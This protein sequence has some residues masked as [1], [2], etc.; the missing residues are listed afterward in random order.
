[1]SAALLSFFIVLLAGLIFSELF[2]RFHLPW[3]LALILA[4][5]VIGPYAADIITID[6]TL[7]F[8]GQIGLVF[9]MFMGGLEA[10]LSSFRGL[11]REIVITTAFNS[12]IPFA[13]GM[14][15]A[16]TFSYSLNAAI[17]LGVIF[18]SSSVSVVL[19]ALERSGYIRNSV[20]R[21][22]LDV[23]IIEDILSLILLSII[24]QT[25]NSLSPLPLYVLYPLLLLIF[26]GLRWI[27][28]H[29]SKLML[30]LFAD[31]TSRGGSHELQVVFVVLI[32]T[33]IIFQILGLHP[34]IGSFL[35]GLILSD[36]IK[37]NGLKNKLRAMGYGL[38]IPIFFVL[39]GMRTNIFAFSDARY[40][41][42][43]TISV[44]S[45]L[46]IAKFTG[47]WLG[48]KLS[49]LSNYNASFVGVATI[50]QLTTT[51]AV[52]F[53]GLEFGILDEKLVAALVVLSALTTFLGP[54][55]VNQFT[56]NKAEA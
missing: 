30:F 36:S 25:T 19:P 39:V 49:G 45:A 56:K 6:P 18:I 2:N 9:L 37:E 31:D 32:G 26:I 34:I 28:K 35:A 52:A 11:R 1:M 16:F 29:V 17:L 53:S 42:V 33:V 41:L 3:V 47:G 4:G 20:G 5:V 27:A 40:A 38:F 22:V 24:I 46:I 44:V 14:L 50:P 8:I 15:V 23:A 7:E 21:L 43:L 51:L 54:F 12:L 13:L 10:R 55:L 48:A